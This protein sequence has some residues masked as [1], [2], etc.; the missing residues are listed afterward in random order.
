MTLKLHEIRTARTVQPL[1]LKQ[2]IICR[3]QDPRHTNTIMK[4]L[5]AEWPLERDNLDH[6]RRIRSLQH[7]S[8]GQDDALS[9]SGIG[10]RYVLVCALND[11]NVAE[12][13][14]RAEQLM[15]CTRH[16]TTLQVAN[17]PAN[18]AECNEDLRDW[19]ANHWPM[20]FRTLPQREELV[21][22][23]SVPVENLMSHEELCA[24]ERYMRAA[25][26]LSLRNERRVAALVVDPG[27]ADSALIAQ[28]VDRTPGGG[29]G[30]G[31][32]A[33][34]Y[35]P[36]GAVPQLVEKKALK[37]DHAGNQYW[38]AAVAHP[39][40]HAVMSAIQMVADREIEQ[41]WQDIEEEEEEEEGEEKEAEGF[42]IVRND[43][44][45][46]SEQSLARQGR[47]RKRR[48]SDA[49][50]PSDENGEKSE[51]SNVPYLCTGY[52]LYVTHEPCCMCCMALI[53]SRIRR[54]FYLVQTESFGG[55]E[56]FYRIHEI[57]SLNHHYRV[58]KIDSTELRNQLMGLTDEN[59]K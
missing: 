52:D 30:S 37:S 26:E 4:R 38:H 40:N 54:V 39:L 24:V 33:S 11:D 3:I 29:V 20:K 58:F 10:G 53:H 32:A 59:S 35:Y 14:S 5:S 15:Q 17:V 19:N 50:A 42:S 1:Q 44:G 56:S 23:D 49:S 46:G 41:Y 13:W 7:R 34:P 48:H 12:C 28:T 22:G 18:A 9:K 25:V 47:T 2:V 36:G 51:K 6:L 55:L 31:G 21:R 45:G 8:E 16:D 57:P 43:D 27:V